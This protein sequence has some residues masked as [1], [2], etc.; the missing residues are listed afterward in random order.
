MIKSKEINKKRGLTDLELVKKDDLYYLNATYI[1]EDKKNVEKIILKNVFLPIDKNS[2]NIF[3][4]RD[5]TN[6][7]LTWVDIGYGN[8][9]VEKMERV[10]LEEKVQEVTMA[11]IEKKF[12]C[13]V[14]IV[15]D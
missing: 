3:T 4:T 1:L 14:K 9:T 12:G 2:F 7:H 15:R 8:H 10:V 6:E 13:K 11:D 5:E